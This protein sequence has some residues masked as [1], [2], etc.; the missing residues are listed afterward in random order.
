MTQS[1]EERITARLHE[2]IGDLIT[3]DDLKAMVARGVEAALFSPRNVVATSGYRAG[4]QEQRPSVVEEQVTRLLTE[5]MDTA[6]NAWLTANPEK[7]EA[8][9]VAV[10]FVALNIIFW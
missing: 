6:V 2:Q 7:V 8:A 4:Y 5:K 1:L 3:E 10:V 9:I